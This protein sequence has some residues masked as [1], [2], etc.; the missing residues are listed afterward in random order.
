ME[1][2][3]LSWQWPLTQVTLGCCEAVTV[4]H[5]ANA[6]AYPALPVLLLATCLPSELAVVSHMELGNVLVNLATLMQRHVMPSLELS[7]DGLRV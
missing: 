7:C 5:T 3:G 6:V 1:S 2:K 4:E